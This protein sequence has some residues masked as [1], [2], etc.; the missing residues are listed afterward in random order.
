MRLLFLALIAT[1][2][3]AADRD[4]A[5]WVIRQGGRVVVEGNPRVID[6]VIDLPAGDVKVTA[7]DLVGTTIP[8]DDL[9]RLSSLSD[10]RELWL[11]GPIFNPGAG[12]R[13]DAN[14]KL[15]ALAPLH[16]LESLNFSLH[17]LTNINVQDKGLDE[18]KGLTGL[19]EM[20]LA[21]TKVKGPG[22]APFVNLEYLD[23]NYTP[24][25]DKGI[26]SLK[27]LKK[28]KYLSLR[29]TLVTDAG[30][31]QI[32]DLTELQTLD[33]YGAR[34]SDAGLRS[35]RRMTKLQRL[36]VLGGTVTDEGLDALSGMPD[37]EE[38]NLYRTG[39]TNSGLAKLQRAGKMRS[40]DV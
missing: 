19:R 22:L 30:L 36:N 40:L 13:L 25:D 31:K 24:F 32:E 35:L 6:S 7:V 18:F 11:P 16:K 34:V 5:A 8:P 4:T 12:S 10:L 33:L 1:L 17:F 14:D 20:R 28:L 9:S 3:S 27:G 39:I 21:Q 15:K 29:D 23:L 38:V 37:L 2:L 26:E